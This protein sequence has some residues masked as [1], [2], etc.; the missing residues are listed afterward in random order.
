MSICLCVYVS[1]PHFALF[2]PPYFSHL[3][4]LQNQ[5]V[6]HKN[7]PW[8]K[9]INIG[10]RFY[11]FGWKTV[12]NCN[13]DFFCLCHSLLIDLGHNQQQHSIVHSGGGS[14][15]PCHWPAPPLPLTFRSIQ[16]FLDTFCGP[17][18][19]KKCAFYPFLSVLILVLLSAWVQRYS[20]SRIRDVFLHLFSSSWPLTWILLCTQYDR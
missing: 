15:V 4:M 16:L 6:D 5:S 19:P 9:R 11:N 2:I 8:G 13:A 18:P 10:L 12:Q 1:V 17:P 14:R 20:V 7:T 3:Q